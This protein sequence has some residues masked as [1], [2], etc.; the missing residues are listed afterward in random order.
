MATLK[1]TK[2]HHKHLNNPFPSASAQKTTPSVNGKL[3]FNSQTFPSHQIHAIG[4]DFQLNWTSKGGGFVSISHKSQPTRHIWSTIPGNAF[5]SAAVAETEV[6]ESRGSFLIKDKDVHLACHHQTIE[7]I[8]SFT[9]DEP[10]FNLGVQDQDFPSLGKTKQNP[11]LIIT[12]KLV[13]VKEKKKK[14]Q[15]SGNNFNSEL[16]EESSTFARYWIMFDQKNSNQI[17]FQVRVGKPNVELH[18]RVPSRI[19]RGFAMK[20]TGIHL[21]RTGWRGFFSRR[22]V[23]VTV[24]SSSREEENVVMKSSRLTDFNRIWLTYR[25]EKTERFFG[26]GE[27]FSHMDFKGKRVPIFVQEQGIG[28]GDQPI[29]FAANLVSYRYAKSHILKLLT[30]NL[31]DTL[32]N[33]KP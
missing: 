1:I 25:S 13:S 9:E 20:M 2:K 15:I 19:Y 5:V 10:D 33:V 14:N 22:K 27:Q 23:Y 6:E 32:H 12:G 4:N 28:R 8:K 18:Q 24:S 31:M 26:F 16:V 11:A 17:G 21:R 30:I 7:Y 29:T 3:F